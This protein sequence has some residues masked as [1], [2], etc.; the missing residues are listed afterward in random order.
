MKLFTKKFKYFLF[1][2]FLFTGNLAYT[3]N[4]LKGIYIVTAESKIPVPDAFAQNED[5]SFNVSADENGF[6]NLKD[7]PASVK[8]MNYP[9]AS[10]LGILEQPQ[11]I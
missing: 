7:L 9:G 5:L 2:C 1:L 4:T 6:I 11:L 10:P 3:Q 8:I